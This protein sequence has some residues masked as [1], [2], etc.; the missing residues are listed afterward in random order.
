LGGWC[1]KEEKSPCSGL[2]YFRGIMIDSYPQIKS[3]KIVKALPPHVEIGEGKS[4]IT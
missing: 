2:S 3:A 4:R 1:E